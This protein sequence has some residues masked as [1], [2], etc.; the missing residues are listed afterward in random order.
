[1]AKEFIYKQTREL[2]KVNANT[3]E[4]GHFVVDGKEMPDKIYLVSHFTRRNGVED[5]KA[6]AICS[7]ADAKEIGK[8]LATV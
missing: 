8:L 2:G 3:L 4:I 1:M 7:L 6:T 5:S